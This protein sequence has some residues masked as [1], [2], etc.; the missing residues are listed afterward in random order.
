MDQQ[1]VTQVTALAGI[2]VSVLTAW[3]G[4]MEKRKTAKVTQLEELRKDLNTCLKNC[5]LCADQHTR[6]LEALEAAADREREALIRELGLRST[7]AEMQKRLDE[8]ARE[9]K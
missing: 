1:L 9:R 6:D 5:E 3:R 4:E 2:L 7:I 8:Y